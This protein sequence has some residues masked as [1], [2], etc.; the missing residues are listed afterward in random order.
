VREAANGSAVPTK[1][2]IAGLIRN[3][4]Q[5]GDNGSA[6]ARMPGDRQRAILQVATWVYAHR[7]AAGGKADQ[8][9]TDLAQQSIEAALGGAGGKGGFGA[10][11][12][13]RFVLP[14]GSTAKDF[15]TMMAIAKP[16]D[17]RGA[18]N[19]VPKWAGR[20]LGLAEFRGLI[21]VLVYDDGHRTAYAFRSRGGSGYVKNERDQDYLLDTRALANV[22]MAKH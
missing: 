14:M 8:L 19:G 11:N 13:G 5:S 16:E 18:G 4:A 3:V 7:A 10:R 6:L 15:D 21:P 20:D 1:D 22:L 12:G 2:G 17:F 9:N